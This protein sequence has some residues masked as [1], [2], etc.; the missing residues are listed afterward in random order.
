MPETEKIRV[1]FT[2]YVDT[3]ITPEIKKLIDKYY[4]T[5]DDDAYDELSNKIYECI[6]KE[7]YKKNI[8]GVE[9]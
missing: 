9:N 7:L 1:Y 2:G 5:E 4:N 8:R 3:N 6:D